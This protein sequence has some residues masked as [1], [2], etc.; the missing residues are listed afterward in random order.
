MN[1]ILQAQAITKRFGGFTALDNVDFHIEDGER[2]G[3]IGPNGSGKS[4]MVNCL[5]GAVPIT[6]GAIRFDG[7]DLVG[8]T[9]HER[10]N[11]GIAGSFQLP[12][13]FRSMSLVQNIR[14]PLEYAGTLRA[15]GTLTRKDIE[16]RSL[17]LLTL[18]GLESKAWR[19][20]NDLTQVELRKLELARALG[21]DP[22]L[23]IADEVMAG[24]SHSE[25]DEILQLL[26]DLNGKGITILLIEH[27]MSAVMRFSQR[28]V[29][30]VSGQKIADGVPEDVIQHPEVGR[31]YIGQ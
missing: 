14:V 16:R 19:L 24:L 1:A 3:L 13:P 29:V 22:K 30:F 25:V 11:L 2:L 28:L 23:L 31:A 20:P 8:R 10:V 26:L 15:G 4:T 12:R 5:C 18:V 7:H 9:A 21:S 27:I 6:S 17:E